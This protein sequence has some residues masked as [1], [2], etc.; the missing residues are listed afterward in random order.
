V[1]GSLQHGDATIVP[2]S[3][4]ALTLA[5]GAP[6]RRAGSSAD[7][8]AELAAH[9]QRTRETERAVLARE[10]HDELGA[11]LTAA[12]LDVAWLAAQPCCEDPAI[13]RRLAALQRV[14]REGIDLKR[15]IVE[16][17]HPTALEHF[18]LVP[19]LEQLLTAHGERYDAGLTV[20]L[21]E[22]LDLRGDVALALYRIVQESLTNIQKYAEARHVRVTLRRQRG[23]VELAVSDDGRGFDSD[24]VAGGCHGLMGMRHRMLA[25]HGRLDVASAPGKGTVI[26]AVLP[27]PATSGV[28]VPDA[29]RQ[30]AVA[31]LV[32]NA[33]PVRQAPPALHS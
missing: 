5:P 19:A 20:D 33:Q 16:D 10:L 12:R 13:A 29:D 14:L 25:V 17:L 27:V 2:D 4:P 15:R 18:G 26:R 21:D 30:S 31:H 1:S 9:L 6:R 22:S 28:A 7:A 8:I 24:A 11:I 32:P 23:R 3:S